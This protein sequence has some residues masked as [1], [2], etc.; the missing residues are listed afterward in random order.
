M[1]PNAQALHGLLLAALLTG[2]TT[3]NPPDRP[4]LEGTS[5][6]LVSLPGRSMV[7][8]PPATL[9]FE[10]GRV[11]GSDGCNRF[12]GTYAAKGATIEL[13]ARP[14]ATLMACPPGVERQAEA[15]RRALAE[16]RSYRIAEGRLELLAADGT[17]MA[18][19]AVQSQQLAGTR[20]RVTGINNGHGGVV[21]VR[22][23]TD[24]TLAFDSD[25]RLAGS[26]GCNSYSAP[27]E[28]G[29]GR[30]RIGARDQNQAVQLLAQARAEITDAHASV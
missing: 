29:N 8:D 5:W 6:V 13:P 15:Y 22:A 7:P 9:Q 3:M 10:G 12:T 17:P 23:G 16:A 21:S 2:C 26:A 18:G 11:S 27:F 28:A 1:H 30:V 25:G 20:W 14:A 24:V 19:L 4:P